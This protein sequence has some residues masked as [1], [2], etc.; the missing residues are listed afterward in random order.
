M[1]CWMWVYV[2]EQCNGNRVSFSWQINSYNFF[3]GWSERNGHDSDLGRKSKRKN[4]ILKSYNV[5]TGRP[6][7]IQG[8]HFTQQLTMGNTFLL[9]AGKA[10][11]SILRG[12]K[13]MYLFNR[14]KLR[15]IIIR[16]KVF[17]S[18]GL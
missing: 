11:C 3:H 10:F 2:S 12:R 17:L 8:P 13:K 7:L 4:C 5:R 15:Q 9:E 1:H 6:R 14:S 16:R 18:S